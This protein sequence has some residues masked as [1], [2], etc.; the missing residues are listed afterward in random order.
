MGLFTG[1]SRD[2]PEYVVVVSPRARRVRLTI[3]A[4]EPV[5]VTIPRGFPARK[6]AGIVADSLPW[7]ERTRRRV[8]LRAEALRE[9]ATE[10]L[11]DDVALPGVGLSFEVVYRRTEATGVRA[12]VRAPGVLTVEGRVSDEDACRAALRR[13]VLATAKRELPVIAHRVAT[14]LGCSPRSITVTWP[15]QRWGSCSAGG[16][17]RLSAELVF[18]PVMQARAIIVHE[19]AHLAVLDHSARFYAEVR[20]LDPGAPAGRRRVPRHEDHTPGW[21]MRP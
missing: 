10:P 18:L 5:R 13:W 12:V 7:I 8:E 2:L 9:R 3:R 19:L 16:D 20:R 1:R 17:V 14:E 11:P 6:A 15:R 21:A 4:G